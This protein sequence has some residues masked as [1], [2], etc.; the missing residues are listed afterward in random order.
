MDTIFVHDCTVA[1][2]CAP[3]SSMC[4]HVSCAG[5]TVV[6]SFIPSLDG[7]WDLDGSSVDGLSRHCTVVVSPSLQPCRHF[8]GTVSAPWDEVWAWKQQREM[9]ETNSRENEN[10]SDEYGSGWPV[11]C[12]S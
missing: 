5:A 4:V 10:A 8:C 3:V 6:A 7:Q 9:H 2:L 11:G 12:C 1:A